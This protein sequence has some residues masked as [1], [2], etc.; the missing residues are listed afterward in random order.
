MAS[1]FS[2]MFLLIND[3]VDILG[4]WMNENEII[5][6]TI[7]KI[8]SFY[9]IYLVI[10]INFNLE[11]VEFIK[12]RIGH[13]SIF[14]IFIFCLC[15]ILLALILQ[16]QKG[17]KIDLNI[18]TVDIN[19]LD[20][21]AIIFFYMIDIILA[22]LILENIKRSYKQTFFILCSLIIIFNEFFNIQFFLE[23]NIL[24][25]FNIFNYFLLLVILATNK[26]YLIST[27]LYCSIVICSTHYLIKNSNYI[28]SNEYHIFSLEIGIL[29]VLMSLTIFCSSRFLKSGS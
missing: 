8:I 24:S 6:A 26:D 21:F 27:L 10:K 3:N 29:V 25:G 19:Y 13:F 16:F 17:I 4:S 23:L 12:K 15:S 14:H 1:V 18:F 22:S 7:S 5:L 11:L 9:I 28:L 2:F 20:I